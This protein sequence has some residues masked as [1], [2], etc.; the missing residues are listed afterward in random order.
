[1][2][3]KY[4]K[5]E[6]I[7]LIEVSPEPIDFAEEMGPFIVHFTSGSKPVLLEILDASEF[8]SAAVKSAMCPKESGAEWNVAV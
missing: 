1:M 2:K 5:D 4:N 6:D 3:M 8:F 7:M